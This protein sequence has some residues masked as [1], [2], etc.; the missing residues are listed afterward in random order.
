MNS[1]RQKHVTRERIRWLGPTLLSLAVALAGCTNPAQSEDTA[2]GTYT[3]RNVNGQQPPVAVDDGA[4]GTME[5]TGGAVRL[6][7]SGN[8]ELDRDLRVT[9]GGTPS[10]VNEAH[11]C[12]WSRRGSALFLTLTDGGGAVP[13]TYD[14]TRGSISLTY[15]GVDMV[16]MR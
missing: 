8:C 10:T 5:I 2:Q 14:E 11:S 3:L 6:L 12:T 4:G 9:S 16:F 7:G 1:E 13:S 15:Q